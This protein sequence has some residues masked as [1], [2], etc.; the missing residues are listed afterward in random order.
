MHIGEKIRILREKRGLSPERLAQLSGVS[1]QYIRKLEDGEGKSI[2]LTIAQKLA[3]GLGV[4]PQVFFD[5][6]NV[7]KPKQPDELLADL[8]VSIKAYIPV[9]EE[10]CAGEGVI[11]IDWVAVTRSR[12]APESLRAYRVRGLCLEPEIPDGSTIIVDTERV[13][14]HGDLVVVIIDGQASIKRYKTHYLEN[15]YGRFRPDEV[16]VHGVVVEVSKKLK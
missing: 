9:Y 12:P 1:P 3:K 6:Q 8:E 4:S 2:T 13:P 15:N 11:P 14:E 10:V 7:V 5:G 16:H